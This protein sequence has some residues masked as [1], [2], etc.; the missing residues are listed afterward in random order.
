MATQKPCFGLER[1]Y[2]IYYTS[3]IRGSKRVFQQV[4]ES[5]LPNVKTVQLMKFNYL[6]KRRCYVFCALV[7]V[8][9]NER[10]HCELYLPQTQVL[11]IRTIKIEKNPEEKKAQ[12]RQ[13]HHQS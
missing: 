5:A 12:M 13:G 3:G 7:F 11:I 8:P 10:L 9:L 1:H 6:H 2:I 4:T